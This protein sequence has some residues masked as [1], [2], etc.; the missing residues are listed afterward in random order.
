MILN[1]EYFEFSEFETGSKRRKLMCISIH[2]QQKM[3]TSKIS[4]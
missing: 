1:T 2:K 3:N 4:F